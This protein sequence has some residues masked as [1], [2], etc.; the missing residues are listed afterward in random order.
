M[1][2]NAIDHSGS[3]AVEIE[4]ETT[5]LLAAFE[6][7][8]EGV[9][10]FERLRSA[11][12]L[13]SEFEAAQELTKGKV[14]TAP[15]RH[16]GEGIFFTSKA[17]DRFELESGR[18][19]WI[20][21]AR[22]GDVALGT[23]EPRRGTRVRV[24]VARDAARP[25][26]EIFDAHTEEFEFTRTSCVVQPFEYGVDFV[27]RSEAKRLVRGLEKFREVVLD[28]A[29]VESVGQGFV[30]EV[31]RVWAREHPETRLVPVHANPAV[32]FMIRRG[33]PKPR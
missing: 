23:C 2:G 19:R 1:L 31:I 16:S 33:L 26:R 22:R 4:I 27:S 15:D 17:V 9:G 29:G 12:G 32:D 25:L 14:T 28:F 24:E 3:E 7:R 11:F 20:V 21:A 6:V 10:V 30:D 8:D 18:T 5:P 13:E